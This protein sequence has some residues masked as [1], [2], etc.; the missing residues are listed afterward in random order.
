MSSFHIFLLT[1]VICLFL[2]VS[3]IFPSA[4]FRKVEYVKLTVLVKSQP[5]LY[6]NRYLALHI[7]VIL[8]NHFDPN[9]INKEN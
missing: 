6:Q 3:T 8:R 9:K 5:N 2:S 4:F 7:D 1:T